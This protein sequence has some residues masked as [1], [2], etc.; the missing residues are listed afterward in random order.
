MHI[1]CT[2]QTDLAQFLMFETIAIQR[3]K[4][5]GIKEPNQ[6]TLLKMHAQE[7]CLLPTLYNQ[8]SGRDKPH[9]IRLICE[10]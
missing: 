8:S 7:G 2:C 4:E 3:S 9:A 10:L 1:L 5:N 6:C